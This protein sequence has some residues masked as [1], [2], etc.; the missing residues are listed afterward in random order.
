MNQ[1]AIKQILEKLETLRCESTV[2]GD[3]ETLQQMFGEELLFVHSAGYSHNKTD[4]L[5]FLS[6]KIKMLEMARP[7]PLDYRFFGEMVVTC[8]PLDQLLQ[9]RVDQTLVPIK[10][11]VTQIW[12]RQGDDWKLSHVHSTRRPE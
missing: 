11:M 6:D 9:R 2:N 3:L 8:G 12:T 10:A 7:A 5:G 4:Y 1:Q